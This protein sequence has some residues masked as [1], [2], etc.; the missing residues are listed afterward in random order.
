MLCA[1]YYEESDAGETLNSKNSNLV[2][3]LTY[4]QIIITWG[5]IW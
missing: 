1:K 5:R 4:T 3:G 2:K